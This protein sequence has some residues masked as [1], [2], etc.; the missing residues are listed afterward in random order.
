MKRQT[1]KSVLLISVMPIT[2]V[3]RDAATKSIKKIDPFP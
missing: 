3:P 1:S 2:M